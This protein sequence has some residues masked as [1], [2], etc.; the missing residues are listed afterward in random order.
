MFKADSE[1]SRQ[2]R[3]SNQIERDFYKFQQQ[4]VL[5][6]TMK[7]NTFRANRNVD[8]G[9]TGTDLN[10]ESLNKFMSS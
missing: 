10:K 7:Q 8:R 6:E 9:P 3:E 2:L 5:N 4:C 1:I